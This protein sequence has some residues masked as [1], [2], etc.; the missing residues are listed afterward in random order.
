MFTSFFSRSN[1]KGAPSDKAKVVSKTPPSQVR[2]SRNDENGEKQSSYSY[3]GNR[4]D[5]AN[6]AAVTKNGGL[7]YA[8]F[9]DSEDLDGTQRRTN[10]DG[11][12]IKTDRYGKR[13]WQKIY[14]GNLVRYIS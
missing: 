4:H 12:V 8:G 2:K 7:L 14:S 10:G 5:F 11:W 3:G 9:T 6:A 13:L 1:Q